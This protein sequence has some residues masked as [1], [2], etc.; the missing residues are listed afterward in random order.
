MKKTMKKDWVRYSVEVHIQALMKLLEAE[1]PCILCPVIRIIEDSKTN[2]VLHKKRREENAFC[3]PF[4]K[5]YNT[6]TLKCCVI[7]EDFVGISEGC[8][9]IELGK[10]EA[11]KRTHLALEE[12][13][14]YD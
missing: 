12:C 10:K 3:D 9:C 14:A 1:D 4:S 6:P 2:A 11:I 5:F 7:C 13:G 8:P